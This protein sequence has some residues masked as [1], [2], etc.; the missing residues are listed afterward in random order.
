ME[1]F[2]E[3]LACAPLPLFIMLAIAAFLG[4]LLRHLMGGGSDGNGAAG[5]VIPLSVD[6]ND[7]KVVE[8]IGPKIE[9]LLHAAGI[10]T[11]SD[12][13]ATNVDRLQSILTEAGP[14]FKMHDPKTWPEQAAYARDGQWDQLK[15]YQD[16]LIG[17]K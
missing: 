5:G 11:W 1:L 17:G 16:F 8:G 2:T 6:P 14:R 13:A 10:G 15:E 12:L 7:L 4:W 9:E 3:I